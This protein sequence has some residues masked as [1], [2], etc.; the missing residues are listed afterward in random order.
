[1]SFLNYTLFTM[2]M[3]IKTVSSSLLIWSSIWSSKLLFYTF[4]RRSLNIVKI[5]V[6]PLEISNANQQIQGAASH[7]VQQYTMN[8]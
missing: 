6:K 1:M 5:I 4:W 7:T 3:W 2:S 8:P